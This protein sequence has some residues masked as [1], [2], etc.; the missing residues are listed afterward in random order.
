MENTPEIAK[1][2]AP[3]RI[4]KPSRYQYINTRLLKPTHKKL[5]TLADARDQ[6]LYQV[7]E[8]AVEEYLERF[9]VRIEITEKSKEQNVEV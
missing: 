9:N 7:I 3:K 1:Q 4:R 2:E 8:I 5:K 6:T